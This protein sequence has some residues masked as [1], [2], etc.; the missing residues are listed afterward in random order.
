M[1]LAADLVNAGKPYGRVSGDKYEERLNRRR[2]LRSRERLVPQLR[3]ED[4]VC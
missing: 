1:G 2:Q 4:A 3:F